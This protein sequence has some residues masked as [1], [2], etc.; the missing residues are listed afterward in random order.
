VAL[1]N[2]D[3]AVRLLR[4]ALARNPD[5]V[6]AHESLITIYADRGQFAESDEHYQRALALGPPPASLLRAVGHA[7]LQQ[8]R[9]GEARSALASAIELDAHDAKAHTLLGL[10][11]RRENNAEK[12]SEWFRKAIAIDPSDRLARLNLAEL[13]LIDARHDEAI[14]HLEQLLDVESDTGLRA[15]IYLGEVLLL[16][17]QTEAGRAR[18]DQAEALATRLGSER[19][20]AT[21]RKM[22]ADSYAE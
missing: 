9:L 22:L 13:L 15:Q 11:S 10:V 19:A 7:R 2:S 17:G 6:A 8:S 4:A 14:G 18:L 21:V 5:N 1:G 12:A 3:D 16:K 20:V